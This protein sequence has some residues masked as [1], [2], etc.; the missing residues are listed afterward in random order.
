[1]SVSPPSPPP[2]ISCRALH[3][4]A[5]FYVVFMVGEP[6]GCPP[7]LVQGTQQSVAFV[8]GRGRQTPSSPQVPR[9]GR[10]R[11][12]FL[13]EDSWLDPDAEGR[14]QRGPLPGNLWASHHLIQGGVGQI[15]SAQLWRV[16]WWE[17]CLSSGAL[18]PWEDSQMPS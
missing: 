11:P 14:P 17:L 15:L 12:G 5:I 18:P 10:R 4:H 9:R 6:K 7:G 1:M 16:G 13:R 8:W 2:L 3:P